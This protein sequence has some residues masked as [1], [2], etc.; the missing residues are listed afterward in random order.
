MGA[1]RVVDDMGRQL[2]LSEPRRIVSL[3]PSD[4]YSVE[5]LGCGERLVGVTD[6]C[7]PSAGHAAV[8]VGGTKHPRVEDI[9]ALAPDLV[10]ANQEENPRWLLERLAQVNADGS[11]IALYVSLPQTFAAGIAHVARLATALGVAKAP[12]ARALLKRGYEEVSRPPW[13][14]KIAAF[15]PI[16]HE[17]W[18]TFN[19]DTFGADMLRRVGFVNVFGDRQRLRRLPMDLGKLPAEPVETGRDARYPRLS[20]DEIAA[21]APSMAILPDEPYAFGDAEAELLRGAVPS[22]DVRYVSGKDLFWSGAWSIDAA[23]RL[24]VWARGLAGR[25]AV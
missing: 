8:R 21:R 10:L 11:R 23:A 16:W 12:A 9:L 4:T 17:P 19:D 3:V 13:P 18:M 7:E 6:Y 5:A 14:A 1:V 15:I 22:L 24:R 20:L 25:K 2:M